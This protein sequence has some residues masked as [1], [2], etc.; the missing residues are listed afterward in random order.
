MDRIK[1]KEVCSHSVNP[2][3]PVKI[4]FLFFICVYLCSS[5]ANSAEI[6][7][8][9]FEPQTI[10][11]AISIGYG[12]EIGEV[13]GDGKPDILLA[14]AKQIV[15][16]KNPGPTSRDR[17]GA[18]PLPWKKF[19][20]AENLT[21]LD[22]VCIAVRDINGDG[23]VEVAVGAQ[24]N[25][26]ETTDP[27][28]SGAIFYLNRPTDPTQKWEPIRIEPHDPT[29]HRMRWVQTEGAFFLAVLPLHGIGNANGDGD[30]V[31]L[32]LYEASPD[33]HDKWKVHVVDTKLHQ[34]HNFDLTPV[35]QLKRDFIWVVG[36]EGMTSVQYSEGTWAAHMAG[37][38]PFTDAA[39][40]VRF[41]PKMTDK[42]SGFVAMVQPMHGKEV[43][44]YL[45]E[46]ANKGRW[47]RVVLDDSLAEGHAICGDNLF[48]DDLY[49]LAAGWRKPNAEGKVGIRM[50]VPQD[51]KYEKWKTYTIDDNTMACEDL[52][53]GDLDG[54]GKPDIVASGR[55]T[56]NVIVYWNR[57]EV[58]K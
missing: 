57:T 34:T 23:K 16:Y 18:G 51:E 58:A 6:P 44:I 49:E 36:R 28:K 26:G 55:A 25:P 3:N 22:N 14:D 53:V 41:K 50:Y 21:P 32:N 39:G 7:E 30:S 54:D 9:K 20:M 5:V 33:R 43:V 31:K 52:K 45:D 47:N 1:R 40:E 2:V 4:V 11:G 8:P 17:E 38:R 56:K 13:D 27:D 42:E 10:D 37:Q 35:P 29:T 12:V 48:G 24:W 46:K 19:I 15:W